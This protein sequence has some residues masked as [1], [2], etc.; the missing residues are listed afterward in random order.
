MVILTVRENLK[1]KKYLY[2]IFYQKI[3]KLYNIYD[4]LYL[5]IFNEV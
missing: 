4:N 2:L 3:L 1:N 5:M